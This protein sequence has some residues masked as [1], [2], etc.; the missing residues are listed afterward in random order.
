MSNSRPNSK[1]GAALAEGIFLGPAI[2]E[3]VP[4]LP[5]P[6]YLKREFSVVAADARRQEGIA[7][8]ALAK[9]IGSRQPKVCGWENPDD[10]HVPNVL[11]VAQGPSRWAARIIRWQA[12]HQ[13][14]RVAVAADNV[15]GDNHLLRVATV[16]EACGALPRQLSLALAEGLTTAGVESV[17]HA[18]QETA[19]AALET[20]QW[21]EERL[22]AQRKARR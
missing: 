9:S 3:Q 10:P 4:P 15:L 17:L 22:R 7:Q 21:A 5:R 8:V 14:L 12:A 2:P 1:S 18:A 13:G 11:Q 20:A 6:K 16:A 19:A